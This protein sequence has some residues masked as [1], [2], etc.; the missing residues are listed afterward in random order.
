MID[1]RAEFT[2]TSD[3]KTGSFSF[4]EEAFESG[5]P[6]GYLIQVSGLSQPRQLDGLR[7]ELCKGTPALLL[8]ETIRN[9]PATAGL[10]FVL[11]SFVKERLDFVFECVFVNHACV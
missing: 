8:R 10:D 2:I 7:D 6:K 9:S 5:R 3:A 4:G 1:V 11:R